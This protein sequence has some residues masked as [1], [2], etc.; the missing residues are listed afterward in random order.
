TSRTRDQKARRDANPA[1]R[2]R[3][4]PSEWPAGRAAASEV[5]ARSMRGKCAEAGDRSDRLSAIVCATLW[6]PLRRRRAAYFGDI[7]LGRPVWLLADY[8]ALAIGLVTLFL[9]RTREWPHYGLGHIMDDIRVVQ[10][11]DGLGQEAEGGLGPGVVAGQD[12]LQRRDPVEPELADL[13][14]HAHPAAAEHPQ[15][16]VAGDRRQDRRGGRGAVARPAGRLRRGPC[17]CL[18]LERLVQLELELELR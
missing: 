18:R 5:T 1:V 6:I 14:D 9:R 13:V 16:L 3:S 10:P 2:E 7:D 17:Q 12:H 15:D 8:V 4:G 11:G